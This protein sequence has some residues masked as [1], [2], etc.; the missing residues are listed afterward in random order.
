MS[1]SI[2]TR[3][4]LE[5][6]IRI[7]KAALTACASGSSYTIGTRSLTRQDM[8]AIRDHLDYLA[9]ELAA[10]T[11]GAGPL[12]VEARIPRR[13]RPFPPRGLR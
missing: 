10:L 1:P 13:G 2:W 3:P 6:Q 7:Y 8:A 5:E 9:G 12:F 4:E 11:R